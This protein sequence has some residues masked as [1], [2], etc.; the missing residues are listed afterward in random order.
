[1][2]DVTVDKIF[3]FKKLAKAKKN[4]NKKNKNKVLKKKT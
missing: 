4:S 1:L 3:I 2:R